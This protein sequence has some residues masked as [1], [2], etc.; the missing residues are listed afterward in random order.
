MSFKSF[1]FT[2]IALFIIIFILSS[3]NFWFTFNFF[4]NAVNSGTVKISKLC[5]KYI[6]WTVLNISGLVSKS[7][8][9]NTTEL[10]FNIV[11]NAFS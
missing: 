3:S 9:I 2:V 10:S 8:S 11:F 6:S 1:D 5:T 7:Q 4:R